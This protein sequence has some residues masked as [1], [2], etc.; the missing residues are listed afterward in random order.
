MKRHWS[1]CLTLKNNVLILRMN[2]INFLN[3][4]NDDLAETLLHFI[5]I[6]M[7]HRGAALTMYTIQQVLRH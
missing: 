5:S 7:A 3:C 6:H 2:N 1:T 4:K